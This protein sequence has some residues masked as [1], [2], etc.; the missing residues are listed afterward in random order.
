M[1][2]KNGTLFYSVFKIDVGNESAK[3]RRLG[4][5]KSELLLKLSA[6]E[7]SDIMGQLY[8]AS[9]FGKRFNVERPSVLLFSK[10]N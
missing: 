7:A 3:S 9:K 8:M 1:S 10:L 2:F 6:D 4:A 5:Y